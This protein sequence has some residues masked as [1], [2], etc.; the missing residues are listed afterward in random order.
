MK[1]VFDNRIEWINDN[2]ELHRL[3]GPAVEFKNGKRCWYKNGYFHRL[4]GPAI[5]HSDGTKY[6]WLD[7]RLYS[8]EKW[9]EAL[10]FEKQI[11]YLFKLGEK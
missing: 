5:E 11:A 8:E 2:G 4:D 7:G 9:F 3:D 1:T 10:T 6:W